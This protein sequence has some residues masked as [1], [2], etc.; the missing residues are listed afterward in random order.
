MKISTAGNVEDII[1]DEEQ[2][3]RQLLHQL[4]GACQLL[5]KLARV[6]WS[7][8]VKNSLSQLDPTNL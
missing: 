8:H 1:V 7:R 2:R 4:Q 6:T 5:A 3:V